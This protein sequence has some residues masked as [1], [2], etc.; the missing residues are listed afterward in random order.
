MGAQSIVNSFVKGIVGAILGYSSGLIINALI[1]AFELL[2]PP[3]I[4]WIFVAG[5]LTAD[6]LFSIAEAIEAGLSYSLGIFF[7]GAFLGDY[8]T[9]ALGLIGVIG[10]AIGIL[11]KG[12]R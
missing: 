2:N 7:A 4:F 6:I 12:A 9:I 3:P 5:L 1:P 10:L 8:S 11:L